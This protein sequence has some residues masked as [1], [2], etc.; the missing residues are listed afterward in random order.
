MIYTDSKGIQ[1]DTKDMPLK[2]IISALKK[3]KSLSKIENIKSL[4]EEIA[5]RKLEDPTLKIETIE[6]TQ[7][8]L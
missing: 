6:D 2:Y 7:G 3:S 1:K 5:L 4:E 8:N